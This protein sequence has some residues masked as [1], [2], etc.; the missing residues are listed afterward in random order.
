MPMKIS[1]SKFTREVMLLLKP[2]EAEMLEELV[3]L[4]S[5]H[6]LIPEQRARFAA[7]LLETYERTWRS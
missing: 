1:I 3:R 6:R 4:A 2:A 7:E 5:L